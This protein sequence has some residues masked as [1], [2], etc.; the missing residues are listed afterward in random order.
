MLASGQA[1]GVSVFGGER[2]VELGLVDALGTAAMVARDVVGAET[3]VDF[4]PTRSPVERLMER[5]S[6]SVAASLAEMQWSLAPSL[7]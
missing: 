2:A 5:F 7:R 6:S 4:T 3:L 1:I